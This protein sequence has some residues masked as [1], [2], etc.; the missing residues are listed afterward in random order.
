MIL[1]LT[2]YSPKTKSHEPQASHAKISPKPRH[3]GS[4]F[5]GM[6]NFLGVSWEELPSQRHSISEE[7]LLK[8][9]FRRIL[10]G[11]I[12][13]SRNGLGDFYFGFTP[14]HGGLIWQRRAERKLGILA[15]CSQDNRSG[16]FV[17]KVSCKVPKLTRGASS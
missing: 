5:Q 7:W 4:F 12:R 9:V 1:Q 6:G 17:N 8:G 16:V 2:L 11:V 15:R 14:G 3:R 10:Q 13:V